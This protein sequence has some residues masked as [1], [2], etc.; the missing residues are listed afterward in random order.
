MQIYCL[1]I[2][3]LWCKI[4]DQLLKS[5]SSQRQEKIMRY[6]FEADKKLSLYAALLTR[7]SLSLA[8]G[9]P[10]SELIFS[11]E[12]NK[13]PLL[14]STSDYQFNL[15][16]TKG[17]ILCGIS[18]DGMLGVDVEKNVS[19]P[20]EVMEQVFHSEE[21]QYVKNALSSERNIR[22]YKVWTRKEAYIKKLGTGLTYGLKSYNTLSSSLSSSLY[23]WQYCNYICSA[24]GATITNIKYISESDVQDYFVRSTIY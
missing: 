15:S 22:F 16:H 4:D 11:I 20:I 6:I 1:P 12:N 19:A 13:K 2:T 3:S 5:V 17:F 8:T 7:L 18:N 9:I 21:I 14:L 23:T 10:A 24:C